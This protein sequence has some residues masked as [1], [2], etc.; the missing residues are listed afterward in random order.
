MGGDA[1][2]SRS[3][4][5]GGDAWATFG[6]RIGGALAA[7]AAGGIAADRV[8]ASLLSMPFVSLLA[9]IAVA[10]LVGGSLLTLALAPLVRSRAELQTRY[11]QALAD[12]LQDPLTRLGNHRAFQEELD[13]QV[14]AAQRYDVPVS[15]AMI[16][17]DQFK[18]VN[19]DGGHADGDRALAAF[20]RL[21]ATSVRRAD[22][23]FRVGGDEF[24]ILL[25]HTDAEG[26]RVVA[27]RLLSAALAPPLRLD[28]F[29]PVSFSAG[30]S[31]LPDPATTRSQLYSQAD[32]ALYAAKRGG[33]T[34]VVVF[35]PAETATPSDAS[36]AAAVAEVIARELV[37][38]AYQ[39]IVA[40]QGGE[41]L[42]VEG[43]VRPIPPA[44]FEHP[45]EL[46]AAAVASG[47]LVALDL[48]CMET[49]V[50]GARYLASDRFLSV[51]LSPRT[52]EA[53]EFTTPMLLSILARHGFDPRRLVLELT[54][55][56]SIDD[57]AR[58]RTKLD[59]CR[60]AGIRLAAD[61]LGA[62]NAGLRLLSELRFDIL[63]VDLSI[64]Q[65]SAPGSASSDV[66]ESVVGLAARTGALVIGEGVE[67]PNQLRQ[68]ATL[69]V[70]AGQ[71]YLLGRP[72]PLPGEPAG[73][74]V[75][76]PLGRP[77][78]VVEP[79]V[80]GASAPMAA[81][82]QSIGLPT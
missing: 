32:A 77:A 41:I 33:R 9:G 65:R 10:C 54:E 17:L 73:L 19:D 57:L 81:W 75:A 45:G 26:A 79:T 46:F 36:A 50:S 60:H 8:A 52:V 59:A 62:G 5:T 70:T 66:V 34:E 69:G 44:S 53:P 20:G 27:R 31:A 48:S 39:P 61:D 80:S 3:A 13:R 58:V 14:E 68:L 23:C 37:R 1:T 51:N 18:A 30:I 12:S 42:G 35:D 71:G 16:D 55:R 38:P 4:H 15:L 22:R 2:R 24:A 56:E 72:G 76:A 7:A 78:R 28:G 6:L 21:L 11:Q 82:R 47:H 40:L 74:G 29:R 25:P 43:L 49:V 67:H 64:V 63:K